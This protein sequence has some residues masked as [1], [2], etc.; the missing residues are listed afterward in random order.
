[1]M[2]E[3]EQVERGEAWRWEMT[4]NKVLEKIRLGLLALFIFTS[5]Y[6]NRKVMS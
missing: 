5:L 4:L 1:M 3:E 6:V 2:S